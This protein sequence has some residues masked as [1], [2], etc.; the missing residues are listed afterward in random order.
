[1]PSLTW[2]GASKEPG[3]D[4]GSGGLPMSPPRRMEAIGPV[5]GLMDECLP[6]VEQEPELACPVSQPDWREGRLPRTVAGAIVRVSPGSLLPGR[7]ALDP[8]PAGELPSMP[9]GPPATTSVSE[10]DTAR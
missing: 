7:A 3:V 6:A 1:M 10:T 5:G 2:R 4:A 9:I 8:R